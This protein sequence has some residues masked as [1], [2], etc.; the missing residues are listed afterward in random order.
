M[1]ENVESS[2]RDCDAGFRE[3]EVRGLSEALRSGAE[4]RRTFAKTKSRESSRLERRSRPLRHMCVNC[5][6]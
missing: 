5:L 6:I 3:D 2:L 4:F 1:D